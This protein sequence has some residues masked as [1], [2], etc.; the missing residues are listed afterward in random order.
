[1]VNSDGELDIVTPLI[2]ELYEYAASCLLTRFACL[3]FLRKCMLV[4][5]LK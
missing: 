3:V 4:C 1:M 5:L 2:A